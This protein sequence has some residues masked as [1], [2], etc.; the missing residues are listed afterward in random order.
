MEALPPL[1]Q[2]T[3][4]FPQFTAQQPIELLIQ[5]KVMSFSGDDFAITDTFKN[6]VFKVQGKVMSISGRKTFTDMQGNHLFDIQRELLHIHQTYV[7]NKTDGT[8]IM[9]VKKK[10]AFLGNK[11]IA[12]F[13][14][15]DGRQVELQLKGDF[16][17][18]KASITDNAQGGAVVAMIKRGL[19]AQELIFGQQMYKL[20]VAPGADMA[21]MVAFAICL[22]EM[23]EAGK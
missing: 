20:A 21:L 5:E 3:A 14:G 4:F 13:T 7:L 22:D 16:F 15:S 17:A 12:T 23:N 18:R 10:F 9:T 6:P 11:A 8:T 2:A 19:S 1:P